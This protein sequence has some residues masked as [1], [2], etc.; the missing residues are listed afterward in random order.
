MASDADT[1]EIREA[2]TDDDALWA[3]IREA[4]KED[5]RALTPDSTWDEKDRRAREAAGRPCLSF[6]EL[7]QY[8]NQLVNDARETKRAI[9]VNPQGDETSE[10]QARFIGALI[11]Q[12]EYRSNAQLAYTQM[13]EDAAQGGYGFLRIVPRYIQAKV[14]QPSARSFDQELIIQPIHN[15]DL[16]T[17]GYFTRPDF[18]DCKRL[19]IHESYTHEDFKA[20]FGA[21]KLKDVSSAIRL[22]GPRWM[23]AKRVWVRELWEVKSRPKELA[24]LPHPQ[25][26]EQGPPMAVW[27]ETIPEKDRASVLKGALKR[28]TVDQPYVCQTIT[29]G[30]EILEKNENWPG[31]WIPVVGCVGKVIWIEDERQ[32]LSLIRNAKGPQQLYNYYRTSEAEMVGMT[33]KFP[34]FYYEGTLNPDN[35]DKLH[36]A[37]HEPIAAV[38]IKGLPEGWNPSWGPPPVPQRNPYEPPIQAFEMGA[39]STRRAI[40]SATGT[41]F[42]P[43]DAQRQNQKS[44]VA[45]RE[46]STSAQKGAFHFVDHY[47]HAIR[48]VGE[49]LVDLIPSYYDS[50]RDIFVRTTDDQPI[51]VRINDPNTP[52]PA[53]FAPKDAEPAPLLATTGEYDITISTGPSYDSERQKASDFADQVVTA[54]PE[55]FQM[56][57][58]LIFKLKNLGPIGD[59]MAER[60]FAML[61]PQLQQ[62]EKGQQPP[63]PEVLQLQQQLQQAQQ[64]LQQMQ[65]MIET[66]QIKG[67]TQ[68][69]IKQL[70]AQV[71]LA[72]EQLKGD[73]KREQQAAQ[74]AA[75]IESREDEQAHEMAL[76]GA[77]AAQAE[78]D[79]ARAARDARL[80]GLLNGAPSPPS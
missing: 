69:Q 34:W 3:K 71:R 7:S 70:D 42:L 1:K 18:A 27:V 26:P 55:T 59:K 28:R 45:L 41:G 21:N 10:T 46:I 22:A 6:D 23:D 50:A 44:G 4:R 8:V 61:P 9:E 75:D 54:K 38:K 36:R 52:A 72:L 13:F 48:R 43:T 67:Q 62:L 11:R 60:A 39:E 35:E 58:D 68:I 56:F 65:R 49:I 29:N 80:S 63:P 32:I 57:A 17:P 12:I 16:V 15:P 19:W 2:Y 37:N 77:D 20:Q 76:A 66:E 40:Q 78:A 30:V 79:A 53:P 5:V 24:L 25:N 14:S 73:Q 64:A 51:Q 33:P 74:V 47:E 31:Q